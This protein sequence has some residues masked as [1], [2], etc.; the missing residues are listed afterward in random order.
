MLRLANYLPLDEDW[1]LSPF[2]G[3]VRG[4]R[5]SFMSLRRGSANVLDVVSVCLR[6]WF[7]HFR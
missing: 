2:Q 3:S 4:F 6:S 7:N 1:P 5:I